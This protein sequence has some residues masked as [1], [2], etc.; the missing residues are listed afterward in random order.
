M[1]IRVRMKKLVFTLAAALAIT[2]MVPREGWSQNVGSLRGTVTDPSQAV[3]PNA[4]VVATGNGVT[5][6]ATSDGQGRYTLPNM[7]PGKYDVRADASGFVTYLKNGIDVPAGQGNGLDIA[8]QIAAETQQVSVQEQTTAALT[9]DSSSNVSAIVLK[10]EDIEALPDDPDDLQADLTALAGPAAGPNGAQFFV[11]GFS[12]GQL[13]PKSSIREIRI[14]SNPFSSEFD[15][16][17]FGRIEILTKPGTDNFHGQAFM[18]FGN[19]IFDSRNP[20]LTPTGGQSLPGY[21]TKMFTAN[22]GG[23]IGKKSSFFIDY[24]RRAINEYALVNAIAPGPNFI[25]VPV[26]QAVVTPNAQWQISPRLDYAINANNTLVVRYNHSQSSNIGGVGAFNLPDQETQ[27]YTR[28][29]QVQIT[30]T[31]VLGTI[32]VDETRFQFRDNHNNSAALGNFGVPGIDISGSANFNG[33][34]NSLTRNFNKG[35]ELQNI[36]TTTRGSHALKAGFRARQSDVTSLSNANFN[37]T[38]AFA[39][40]RNS[41]A[42]STLPVN[43][44][45][46]DPATGLSPTTSLGV[47]EATLKGISGGHSMLDLLAAGCG[48]TQFTLSTSPLN[49]GA[50]IP[51]AQQV[52][53]FDLGVFVQDDWRIAPNFTVNAGLRYETQNNIRDHNDWAPRIGFAWAPGAKGKTASKTVIRGGYGIFFDRFTTNSY[54]NALRYN[55]VTQSNYNITFPLGTSLEPA[56]P[57]AQ[58]LSSFCSSFVSGSCVQS[59]P[60]INGLV[61]QSQTIYKI[62]KNFKAPYMYQTAIGVDRQLPGRTQVS[63]NFVNTRGVHQQRL[64]DINAPLPAL[65]FAG[66][67]VRPYAGQ[68]FLGSNGDIQLYESSG[69][70]KQTQLTVNA[71]SRVNSHFQVQGYYSFGYANTNANGLPMNQYD[72]SIEWGRANF[73]IR[74]R[75]F[76]GGTIGL[77]LKITANPFVT[78]QTGAPY[79]ITTGL[80]FAGDNIIN[81]RPALLPGAP[82]SCHT[83]TRASVSQCF[84]TNPAPGSPIIPVNYG[85]GPGEF[86]VNMRL[87]RSWG[88]GERAGAANRNRGGGD[89][90]GGGFPGGG[91]RGGGRG[92][93]GFQGGGGGRGGGGFG[94]FG[95][96]NNGKRYNVTATVQARNAFNHV[97]PAAPS[98]II[99]SPFFGTSTA[100]AG[101]GNGGGGFAGNSAAGNR[102]IELQLRFQF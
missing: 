53:E 64:R 37:G 92:G 47:Y 8:L 33:S 16:P 57:V 83:P 95:G 14:N 25:G 58:L 102:K 87:S 98:G 84:N 41:A 30:E 13:P 78:M 72:T 101:G 48:P 4:T 77:P 71:N 36:L 24:N 96:G 45:C 29:N 79:N 20:F 10:E 44:L 76:F 89:G 80:P 91:G 97:N 73:D 67:V 38:W 86:S 35:Y 32:A 82:S 94:G 85:D 81:A 27:G 39:S 50:L 100:L 5:R 60:P 70:F 22:L 69:I 15:R 68:P 9:T 56:D 7:P 26:N 99:T 3:V 54:L 12:G 19:K 63:I 52:R 49:P 75:G 2:G 21:D 43:P 74:H 28:N 1:Q 6:T 40:P 34:P 42:S 46:V 17:G 23:P 90:G 31:A 62:D 66:S 93:G 59:Q 65:Y 61:A 11:D 18:N 55:G 51:P 88:W